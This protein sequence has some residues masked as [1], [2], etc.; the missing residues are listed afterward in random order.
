MHPDLSTPEDCQALCQSFVD[1]SGQ[2]CEYFSYEWE[3]FTAFEIITG[4][5]T[6]ANNQLD[7]YAHAAPKP[8]Q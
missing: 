1:N 8:E 4:V 7:W 6:G 5:F 2:A 3:S